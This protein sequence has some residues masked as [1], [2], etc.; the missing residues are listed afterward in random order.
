MRHFLLSVLACLLALPIW[1]GSARAAVLSEAE[2]KAAFIYNFVQFTTWPAGLLSS[3]SAI[4]V[5]VRPESAVGFALAGLSGR[6][7]Q[8]VP[9]AQ[10]ALSEERVAACH[11]VFVEAADAGWLRRIAA[12]SPPLPI[13]T[14]SDL[15]E[16]AATGPM[17]NLAVLGRKIAFDVDAGQARRAGLSISSRV[18]QLARSVK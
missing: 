4:N 3:A 9:L 16:P 2:A 15:P 10:V 8:G 5:C 14:L 13:L 12:I 7:V 1:P 18:L 11:V 17:I 6:V